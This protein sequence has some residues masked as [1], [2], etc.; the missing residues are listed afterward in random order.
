MECKS[1][2]RVS[3]RKRGGRAG[4]EYRVCERGRREGV[5]ERG[6]RQGEQEQ[7][8]RVGCEWRKRVG[9]ESGV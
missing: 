7:G 1:R 4:C 3:V 6:L 8:K 9:C 2:A 5:Q